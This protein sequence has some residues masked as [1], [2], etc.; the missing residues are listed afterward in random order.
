MKL[1]A[2]IASLVSA[3][4]YLNIQGL[5]LFKLLFYHFFKLIFISA[6]FAEFFAQEDINDDG[7]FGKL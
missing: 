3:G 5:V 4:N 7:L 6:N 1:V 2:I